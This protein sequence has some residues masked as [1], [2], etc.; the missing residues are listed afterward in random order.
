ME[1]VINQGGEAFLLIFIIG[2]AVAMMLWLL[3]THPKKFLKWILK[4]LVDR[5]AGGKPQEE[6]DSEEEPREAPVPD[7]VGRPTGV[8]E[9]K[10]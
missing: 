4:D 6:S 10:M 9:S 8:R 5:Y 2:G 3:V 7:A 1:D